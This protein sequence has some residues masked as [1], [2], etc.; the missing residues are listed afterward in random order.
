[1]PR[2]HVERLVVFRDGQGTEAGAGMRR[3][4]DELGPRRFGAGP[5]VDAGEAGIGGDEHASRALRVHDPGFPLA[6]VGLA[7]RQARGHARA[8]VHPANIA[9]DRS[10]AAAPGHPHDH[11]IGFIGQGPHHHDGPALEPQLAPVAA[12]AVHGEVDPAAHVFDPLA[13]GREAIDDA[14]AVDPESLH[15]VHVRRGCD[16]RGLALVQVDHDEA[17]ALAQRRERGDQL[18]VGRQRHR[19]VLRQLEERLDGR[20]LRLARRIERRAR[21][22][23]QKEKGSHAA[24]SAA[25]EPFMSHPTYPSRCTCRGISRTRRRPSRGSRACG[26]RGPRRPP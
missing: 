6:D 22:D 19:G 5:V 20:G 16:R 17:L 12:V 10:R 26:S 9:G 25:H 23:Q 3:E 8:D 4:F 14:V 13:Q 21:K 11:V 24:Y 15:H 18:A 7:E 2:G 1:M